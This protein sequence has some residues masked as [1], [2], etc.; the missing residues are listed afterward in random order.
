L[1]SVVK[2]GTTQFDSLSPLAELAVSPTV[3]PCEQ[4]AI[5]QSSSFL[6]LF[7]SLKSTSRFCSCIP[8]SKAYGHQEWEC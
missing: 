7:S 6:I 3:W 8:E 5:K 1:V 4:L 2:A